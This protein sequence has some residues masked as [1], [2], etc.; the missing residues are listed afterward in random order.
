MAS[1]SRPQ[2]TPY[3][4]LDV[5]ENEWEAGS[6]DVGFW[7]KRYLADIPLTDEINLILDGLFSIRLESAGTISAHPSM[8]LKHILAPPIVDA[9]EVKVNPALRVNWSNNQ[10]T[11]EAATNH[12]INT[13]LQAQNF[14]KTTVL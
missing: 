7:L 11:I 10:S 1:K 3:L 9:S 4:T 8:F 2:N 12:S 6:S 14:L 5:G 13:H